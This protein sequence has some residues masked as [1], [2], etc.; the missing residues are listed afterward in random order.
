MVHNGS[1][2]GPISSFLSL[3][4]RVYIYKHKHAVNIASHCTTSFK[5]KRPQTNNENAK[6]AHYGF[7]TH[8]PGDN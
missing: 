3:T 8:I 5:I 2:R 4:S 7:E 6:D 1:D